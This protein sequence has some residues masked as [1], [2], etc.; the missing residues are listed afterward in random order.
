MISKI[1]RAVLNVLIKSSGDIDTFTAYRRSRLSLS[2]FG[3]CVE[4]LKASEYIVE[5][6]YNLSLSDKGYKAVS[7][8]LPDEVG[9]YS[10][11]KIPVHMRSNKMSVDEGYI[12]SKQ[13]LDRRTFNLN[14]NEVN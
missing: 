6:G 7:R 4:R 10:W 14:K 8:S 11:K 9:D 1:D 5:N 3:K 13:L 12:P 2:E